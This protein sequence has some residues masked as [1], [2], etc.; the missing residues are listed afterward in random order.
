MVP[1]GPLVAPD[2]HRVRLRVEDPLLQ[3]DL[4]PVGEQQ[5]QVL[6][7]LA[8]EERLHHVLGAQVQRV[9]D[10]ADGRVAAGGD[11]A[12]LFDA[13]GKRETEEQI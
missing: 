5:V 12:V 10:V 13:L 8:Q 7:R 1:P 9:A 6:E 3:V 2:G 4:V 11:L